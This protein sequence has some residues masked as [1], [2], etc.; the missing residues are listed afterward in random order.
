MFPDVAAVTCVV[1]SKDYPG[2]SPSSDI[3]QLDLE[4]D[5]ASLHLSFPIC[6]MEII[7][8]LRNL[9]ML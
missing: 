3:N 7:I 5:L 9:G 4:G 1:R 8:E 2:S 6:K